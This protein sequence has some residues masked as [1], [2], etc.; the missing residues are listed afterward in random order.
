[1]TPSPMPKDICC[2][3]FKG[4]VAYI[5]NHYGEDGVRRLTA[6]LLDGNYFVRDKFAPERL[7]PI[8]LEHLVDPAYWV[9]NAF[10]LKLL[11][12]VNRIVPG[13]NPLYTAGLGVV[14]ENLSRT[15]LFAAK[16]IG[17]RRLGERAA[18]INARFNR[19]KDVRLMDLTDTTITFELKYRDGYRVTKDVC[20]WNLGIYAGIGSLAGVADITARETACVLDGAPH[21]RFHLAWRKRRFLERGLRGLA[22]P[23][24]HWAVHDLIADYEH[25]IEE[26]DALIEKLGASENK[27]R[28]LFEDSLQAMSLSLQGRLVDVNPAWLKLHGYDHKSDVLGQDVM[29]F[30][31]PKDRHV[32]EERRTAWLPDTKRIVRMRDIT[33]SG[34]A[35]DVEIFS[36]GIDVDGE[37]AVLTTVKDIAELK[38]AEENRLELESRLQRAEKMEAVAALAGGV[39]HDLNNILSGM[40]GY[41][42]LILMDLP[43]DSPLIEPV[44]TIQDSGKKAAA[45]VQDLLTLARRGVTTREITSLN[46]VVRTY[47]DSPEYRKMLSYHPD[48]DVASQ[49][50]PDLLNLVGSPVHL[51]K[52]VMNLVS[53]AA[54]AMPE[55]GQVVLTTEN[56]YLDSHQAGFEEVAE[57]E[58][59][60]LAVSDTGV[61]IPREDF[62]KIFEPFY[63]RKKMGRSGTGLGMAVVWGT[64]KDHEG[65]IRIHST[66]GQG[67]TIRLYL[68]ATRE[69]LPA[70]VAA[71]DV[72]A[73]RGQGEA[74]LVVD[75]VPEQRAIAGRMLTALGYRVA[76]AAS[77]EEA[78]THLENTPCDL[79]LLDMIM[80]P[81]IDG[82]ETY[83]RMIRLRPGL[84]AVIA[85]GFS[86]TERVKQAQSLGAGTFISK[87]YTFAK[88]GQAVQDELKRS[89]T[90]A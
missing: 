33:R 61:G 3:N 73:F 10:S 86:A 89:G 15:I 85:S 29:A 78:L 90:S 26:R 55:G 81:G 18:K 74:V 12:N 4:L 19:T 72:A 30:V 27:Y 7:L 21:C 63:T 41:P 5:R 45:I 17:M 16:V 23:L 80:D 87:P 14:Q 8:G 1:M 68:P 44:R 32:L 13:P 43:D 84:K 42:D 56:R 20:N 2:E 28:T 22:T 82:L 11:G 69:G 76:V 36:C 34:D 6:G 50:A 66:L 71:V 59:C 46:G 58:Y 57:G 35:I 83:R 37:P 60:V 51:A 77:G 40:V 31:H 62:E 48:V 24:L 88:L 70:A 54:E 39:A 67:T 65:F 79:V 49:L 25:H 47:L 53:N 52:T 38:R 64:V 75:D 9:S